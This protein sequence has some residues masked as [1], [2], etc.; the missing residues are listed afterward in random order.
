[1]RLLPWPSSPWN[2]SVH[3]SQDVKPQVTNNDT[4][5]TYFT[6]SKLVADRKP[7]I[8]WRNCYRY[9]DA[10]Y[11]PWTKTDFLNDIKFEYLFLSNWWDLWWHHVTNVLVQTDLSSPRVWASSLLT[12]SQIHNEDTKLSN[13]NLFLSISTIVQARKLGSF[14]VCWTMSVL[15]D[16]S[17]TL[18]FS[19]YASVLWNS[20]VFAVNQP[21]K[22]C[23]SIWSLSL[24]P[25]NQFAAFVN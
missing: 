6:V 16:I 12:I 24:M 8:H 3:Y 1:M 4:L 23:P 18:P 7:L 21:S 13:L 11:P 17:R 25:R 15:C 2:N 22:D 10:P 9:L 19:V 20:G 5:L 14:S